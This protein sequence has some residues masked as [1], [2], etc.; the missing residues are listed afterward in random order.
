MHPSNAS[1]IFLALILLSSCGGTTDRT[2]PLEKPADATATPRDLGDIDAEP[3][4]VEPAKATSCLVWT[5]EDDGCA[6]TH[7]IDA[8]GREIETMDGIWIATASGTWRWR[9]DDRPV[10]TS[11][12]ERYDDEGALLRAPEPE[13][14]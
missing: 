2:A 11:A 5:R 13:P 1:S 3:I 7:R 9:E 8:S 6:E 4:E 10:L 12:C 14:G